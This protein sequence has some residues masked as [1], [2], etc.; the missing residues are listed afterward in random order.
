MLLVFLFSCLGLSDNSSTA[1]DPSHNSETKPNIVFINLDDADRDLFK[2]EIMETRFPAMDAIAKRGITF[3]NFHV[4]TPLCGPS[5]ACVLRGQYAHALEHRTN[6]AASWGTRGFKGDFATFVEK[7]YFDD[8]I[9]T[10]MKAAGYHTVFVGKYINYVETPNRVPAGWND[11][12]RSQG[13]KY[14]DTSRFTN[15]T[16]AQ[17]TAERIPAGEYRTTVEA[18]DI[19]RII[20]DREADDQPMFVYFA[21]F[22][23]HS[24]GKAPGGMIDV[25][26]ADRWTNLVR[27]NGPDFDEEDISDKPPEYQQLPRLTPE[28]LEK[29]NRDYRERMLAT[30]SIDRAIDRIVKALEDTGKL[31]NTYIFITSD[32]G[33]SLGEHRMS[34]K[35]NSMTRSAHVPLIVSGPGVAFT[36]A[37]HLLAHIDLAPT[38]LELA[39][40]EQKTFFDGK[41]FAALLANAPLHEE[42]SWRDS[43]LIENW[44]ARR[45][46]QYTIHT[47]Y[48][49]L[50]M[51]DTAYTEWADG[52]REFYDLATDPF[53]L[54]NKYDELT[55]A[56]KAEL[57]ANLKASRRPIPEPLATV[58]RPPV[59]NAA[60]S[61]PPFAVRGVA[62]DTSGIDRVELVIRKW[63]TNEYWNGEDWQADR[64]TLVTKLK[65]KGG[66]QAE[67]SYSFKAPEPNVISDG[68]NIIPRAYAVNG[69]YT[70]EVEVRKF[71]YDSFPPT[72]IINNIRF[73]ASG[74]VRVIGRARDNYQVREVRVHLYNQT[75]KEYFDGSDWVAENKYI[76]HQTDDH[77]KWEFLS[78]KLTPAKYTLRARAY[79]AA[80][81]W[82][83]TQEIRKFEIE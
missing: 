25:D 42:E 10:W 26:D 21:P 50:R 5:R 58:E 48:S 40:G 13:S 68:Y 47:T 53:E 78:P 32:N 31:E 4:T 67:W 80:G 64:T 51:Y 52:S 62:E 61:G 27:E 37:N 49:Q 44:Q 54:E 45:F 29:F 14:Y 11:Y 60:I 43:V 15:R 22:G 28:M 83:P 76:T 18:N 7:G 55:E 34:G 77:D 17:G 39:G 23:P 82:D 69:N 6:D 8:D 1:A 16:R 81:N 65:N 79:D 46:F 19:V 73:P 66:I 72:T 59:N 71:Q 24:E 57:S 2:P 35:G 9:G 12:Y 30:K 36:N 75:T 63:S 56:E 20:R 41:S 70:R 38:F 33:Y 3:T 74:K